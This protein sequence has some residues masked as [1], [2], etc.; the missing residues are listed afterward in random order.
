MIKDATTIN[1]AGPVVYA[2]VSVAEVAPNND[3]TAYYTYT[4][5]SGDLYIDG[6]DFN[7]PGGLGLSNP[8][9]YTYMG[10]YPRIEALKNSQLNNLGGS[11]ACYL[12]VD[13]Y[14]TVGGI[15]MFSNLV[16]AYDISCYIGS[17]AGPWDYYPTVTFGPY[18]YTVAYY[19]TIG[20]NNNIMITRPIDFSTSLPISPAPFFR[21][22][23]NTIPDNLS[24]ME[25]ISS[26]CNDDNSTSP[27]A[28]GL[29]YV[30][31]FWNSPTAGPVTPQ[32]YFKADCNLFTWKHNNTTGLASENTTDWQLYPNPASDHITLQ[33]SGSDIRQAYYC[34]TDVLG[35]ELL[36]SNLGKGKENSIG[37]ATLV[38]GL[39]IMHLYEE[40]KESQRF[41]F[42]KE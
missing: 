24:M 10:F 8:V 14:P 19:H 26:T 5:P 3:I 20:T 4:N 16:T 34:V 36:R 1:A 33:R 6:Y 15:L 21:V 7:T 38:P 32:V 39:Y 31:A 37:I 13:D 42:T 22:N 41:K 27:L 12:V 18:V 17:G 23:L 25:T 30:Y 11:N 40:D 29:P 2:D 35:R 28:G 9:Y